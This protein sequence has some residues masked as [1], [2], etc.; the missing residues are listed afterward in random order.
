MNRACSSSARSSFSG[1]IEGR[2]EAA[3]FIER[4]VDVLAD[5]LGMDPVEL[6]VRIE[7]R[8]RR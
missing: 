5:E 1:A 4:I 6:R 8:K 7:R 3:Y 2:P